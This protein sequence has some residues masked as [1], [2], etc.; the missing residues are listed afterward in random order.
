M[1]RGA[2]FE[3]PAAQAHRA[4]VSWALDPAFPLEELCAAAA[5]PFVRPWRWLLC[6]LPILAL[7]IAADVFSALSLPVPSFGGEDFD[8][9]V[10]GGWVAH[11]AGMVCF[12]SALAGLFFKRHPYHPRFLLL[13]SGAL[14]L[15][16]V[17]S[18]LHTSRLSASDSIWSPSEWS[19][20]IVAVQLSW[21]ANALLY[22]LFGVLAYR[23]PASALK[24]PHP[25]D[26]EKLDTL[27]EIRRAELLRL[28]RLA[29]IS[30]G[31]Q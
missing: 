19:S 22:V 18:V 11:Y 23:A 5:A 6:A 9:F 28:E 14:L 2:R 7:Y 1:R 29:G 24:D 12:L 25:D 8:A 27:L 21:L 30:R 3:H 4:V 31:E 13:F 16:L 17:S 15:F 26:K 10:T 20:S